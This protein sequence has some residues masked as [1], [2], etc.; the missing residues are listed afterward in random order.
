MI[1]EINSNQFDN[2]K[3][4]ERNETRLKGLGIIT[5][6]DIV[7]VIGRN[8]LHHL[9]LC[10]LLIFQIFGFFL[11]SVVVELTSVRRSLCILLRQCYL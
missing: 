2:V 5:L 7:L 9:M 11:D 3:Q 10:Y 8:S 1:I 4:T 6:H